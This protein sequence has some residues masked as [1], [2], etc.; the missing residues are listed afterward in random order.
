M[1]FSLFII[2][3]EMSDA[4]ANMVIYVSDNGFP[5]VKNKAIILPRIGLS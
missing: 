5:R 4:A 3:S 1:K 2:T